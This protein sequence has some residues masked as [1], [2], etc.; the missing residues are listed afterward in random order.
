MIAHF[1]HLVFLCLWGGFVLAEVVMELA[2]TDDATRRYTARMHYWMDLLVELPLVVGVV[3][4]GIILV[5]GAW[6]L[7]GLHVVK[8]G[9]G[10]VPVVV[11]LCCIRTVVRRYRN[12][13]DPDAVRRHTRQVGAWAFIG[14]PFA[15]V[16]AVL[17]LVYFS[18]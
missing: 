1:A 11:N 14:M 13:D 12:R 16:A 15:A 3:V 4:T 2:S 5:I 17:G 18:R 9:A 6:P 7:S 10:L 8:I